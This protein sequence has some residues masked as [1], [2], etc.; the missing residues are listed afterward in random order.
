MHGFARFVE[1]LLRKKSNMKNHIEAKHITG[2]EH[3]CAICGK[4][5]R[6]RN[7]LNAHISMT[8]NKKQ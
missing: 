7:S 6:S 1:Q 4:T 5:Y 3:H 2:M 8:H